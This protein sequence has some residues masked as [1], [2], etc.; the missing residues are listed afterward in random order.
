MYEQLPCRS[1]TGYISMNIPEYYTTF[2]IRFDY[3]ENFH[4]KLK[5]KLDNDFAKWNIKLQII[6]QYSMSF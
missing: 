2:I 4:T 3:I 5:M 6:F 1:M